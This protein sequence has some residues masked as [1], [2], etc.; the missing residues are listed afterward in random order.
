M[1]G[2]FRSDDPQGRA[3]HERPT[4]QTYFQVVTSI[5]KVLHPSLSFAA[6]C[7]RNLVTVRAGTKGIIPG[8]IGSSPTTSEESAPSDPLPV[9]DDG[10]AAPVPTSA[11]A[12]AAPP[13]TGGQ[14]AL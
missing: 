9:T 5:W 1:N 4:H 6:R 11:V 8:A 13:V 14:Q 12:V 10:G 2:S 3:L 7:T